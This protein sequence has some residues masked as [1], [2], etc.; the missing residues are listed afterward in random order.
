MEWLT[1]Q[2]EQM[3]E[4][5][6]IEDALTPWGLSAGTL[7]GCTQREVRGLHCRGF[8]ETACWGLDKQPR[9]VTLFR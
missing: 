2:N 1:W 8:G 3:R 5:L 4:S 7:G 6:F 9:W